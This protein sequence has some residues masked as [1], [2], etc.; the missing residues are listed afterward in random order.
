VSLTAPGRVSRP[1]GGWREG[2]SARPAG[3]WSWYAAAVSLIFAANVMFSRYLFA[4]SLFDLYAG[5]YIIGHHRVPHEN[6]FTSEAHGAGWVDQQWLAHVLYYGAW[7]VGGYRLLALF[8]A[9]LVTI[10]FALLALLMLR[11][12]VPA[13]RMFAWTLA[14][15]GVCMGNTGI[16]AQSFGYPCL[17]VALWLIL[18]DDRAPR[19]RARTWLVIP[20]LVLWANTHG[21]V[22]LG[23]ALVVLYAGYRASR[24]LGRG[25]SR[26][27]PAC[28]GLAAAAAAALL[29][30]PYGTAVIWY[31][32]RFAG[33]PVLARN[34][35][36]W[37]RPTLLDPFSWA[38]FA[39]VLATAVAV[40]VGWR[41]G[42]RP[43]PLLLGLAIVLLALAL[44]AV[45]NQAWFAFGGSLLAA[46]TLARG[47]QGPVPVLG[48]AFRQVLA[49]LLATLAIVS[50]G[51]LAVTP[52]S[53]FESEMP[54]R[55]IGVAAAIAGRNPALRVLG[56]DWSGTP[57]LWLYPAM[58]G[59][60]GFDIRLEQYSS[61]Q[62]SAY[63]DFLFVHPG[64]QRATRGYGLVVV[65]RRE[66][67]QLAAGL[68]RLPGWR[69]VYQD[70]DGLV[71]E[72]RGLATGSPANITGR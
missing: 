70:R 48:R 57:M 71:L 43:D 3:T 39:L 13:T 69:I 25:E 35:V 21:S 20:V 66:H 16:R 46:D 72:R 19:L 4:D 60:V 61:Q 58:L 38:F 10:G 68:E 9:V 42:V 14:A 1:S 24:A 22:L 2:L 32:A 65:S 27:L 41:R 33:N 36:E 6:V 45:R 67:P 30:T 31:Y 5:R 29:C 37:S 34:I 62:L 44:T 15:F 59:R 51:V 28:L 47:R 64:W 8:S 55:A 23:S 11:R 12:G 63:I 52:A 54:R 26:E 50:L 17:A 53:Q 40:A 49:G 18:E 7:A 56:D